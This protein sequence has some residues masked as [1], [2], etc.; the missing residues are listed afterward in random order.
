MLGNQN[1]KQALNV[2]LAINSDMVSA[3][4]LWAEIYE[5]RAPWVSFDVTATKKPNDIYSLGL[6]AGIAREIARSVTI[7]MQAEVTG[8]ARADFLNDALARVVEKMRHQTE[9]GVAKGGLVMKPYGDGKK[10]AVDFVQADQFYPVSFDSDGNITGAVFVDRKKIK[11][12]WYTRLEYHNMTDVGCD[13]VNK[14]FKS[15]TEEALGSEVPLATVDDWADILPEATIRY[16]NKPLFAYFRFPKANNI[17][18]DSPLGVSVYATV[19]DLIR[20]ADF[21]WSRFLWEMEAGEMAIHVD[22]LAFGRDSDGKAVLPNKRLYRSL[23]SSKNIGELSGDNYFHEWAPT[24]REQSLLNGLDAILRRVEFQCGLA[25]GTLSNPQTVDKTATELKIA[26]QRSAATVTDT[27][28]ALEKALNDL[29]YAMD[30]WVTLGNLAPRGP[31]EASFEW[32]DSII[33]DHEL[34]RQQDLQEQSR[35]IMSKLEYRMRNFGETEDQAREM[36]KL[37]EEERE[38]LFE[39]PGEE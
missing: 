10:I 1:I 26:K 33:I 2:D 12:D 38:P 18:S 20:Q 28:K 37:V 9:F 3:L 19:E 36:L 25:Y 16:I 31:Y 7:E 27:Q 30:V 39:M 32:D 14:A 23:G 29:L 15:S 17:D 6:G 24:L 21:Q 22:E 5:N 35:G 34:Q 8:S 11:N 4:E 13:I